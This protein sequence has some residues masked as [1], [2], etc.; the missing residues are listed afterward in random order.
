MIHRRIDRRRQVARRA[1]Q[2]GFRN[3]AFHATL[4]GGQRRCVP[5]EVNT[6]RKFIYG[7]QRRR[8]VIA[9]DIA[10]KDVTEQQ[11]ADIDPRTAP[12]FISLVIA[13]YPGIVDGA[14]VIDRGQDN[15]RKGIVFRQDFILAPDVQFVLV[16]VT[17]VIVGYTGRG[18]YIVE[19]A[20][21]QSAP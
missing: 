10:D 12:D 14:V 5:C 20:A 15:L 16:P 4:Y 3:A 21:P 18:R 11:P 19:I 1:H 13:I 8:F 17:V 6:G 7:I 2:C 9:A